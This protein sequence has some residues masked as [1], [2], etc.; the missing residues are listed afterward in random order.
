VRK[1][2]AISLLFLFW[3][4]VTGSFAVLQYQK[5][6]HRRAVKW[7]IINHLDRQEL[8]LLRFSLP[9]ATAEL[10]WSEKHEFEYR[11]QWYDVVERRQ[12]PD[13]LFLWC[14]QDHA[15]T[16]LHRQIEQ[17]IAQAAGKNPQERQTQEQL[18]QFLKSLYCLNRQAPEADI[19]QMQA[20]AGFPSLAMRY[21]STS[22][23]PPPPPPWI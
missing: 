17:T 12:T 6:Q 16:A 10:R 11:G 21:T 23:G 4:P 18:L 14:W 9:V 13:S 7:Q 22:H 1:L 20:P 5:Y 2:T 19:V 15:E 3:A 8:T